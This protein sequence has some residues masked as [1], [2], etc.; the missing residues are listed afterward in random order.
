MSDKI[1]LKDYD[2]SFIEIVTDDGIKHE[3]GEYFT[4]FAP[5]YQFHPSFKNKLW[6]G[7]IRLMDKRNS[8]LYAGLISHVKQF[9]DD[10]SYTCIDKTTVNTGEKVTE[11]IAY[12]IAKAVNLPEKMWP[13]D[14]QAKYIYE[15]LRDNRSL[16]L[17]PT[18]SGKSL[19]IYL[20]LSY[21]LMNHSANTLIIVPT[22]GLVKQM[23][24]DLIEYGCDPEIIHTISSGADKSVRKKVTLSTWQSLASI[25]DLN[26]FQRFDVVLGDEAHTFNAKSLKDIMESLAQCNWRHGFTGT[27][28]SD[29]RV[30]KLV[31]E[32]LFGSVRKHVSTSDLIKAGTVATFKV[33]AI[34]LKHDEQVTKDFNKALKLIKNGAKRYTAEREFLANNTRRNKFIVELLKSLDGQNNLVLFDL[35]EKHGKILEPLLRREGR[36]LHFIHG[37]ISGD[38]RE[39]IRHLVENDPIKQHD[40]LASSGTFAVGVNLR[41][42]DNAIFVSSSKS[43]IKVLQ[44]IGRTLRKG[45]G[46]DDARLF[47]ITDDLSDGTR[48]NYTLEHFKKRIEIYSK[49]RFKFK[50]TTIKL[51]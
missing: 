14:Y 16:N 17:S 20:I 23:Q 18:S 28:S 50:L 48:A 4:F 37:G 47:D 43:E 6:D 19:I 11:N 12:E 1:T 38:E 45:N 21:Y 33:E 25:K 34:V 51:K 7:K 49:E 32:G 30:N 10:N 29:S 9:C 35:V 24:G 40:I 44:S 22:V 27:I 46:S 42:I 26:W 15:A 2:A 5:G 3:L 8:R 39:R 31:L 36:Q 13:R 41:R